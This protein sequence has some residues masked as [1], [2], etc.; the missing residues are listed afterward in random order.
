[1]F[2]NLSTAR[3]ISS[4][5]R[6]WSLRYNRHSDRSGHPLGFAALLCKEPY[7]HVLELQLTSSF[8][9]FLFAKVL[10]IPHFF[11]SLQP[12]LTK[13]DSRHDSTNHA[14]MLVLAAPRI[15]IVYDERQNYI[16]IVEHIHDALVKYIAS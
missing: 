12:Y 4:P 6:L 1:M 16:G 8:Y 3:V 7:L 14:S 9:C 11:V 5:N 2:S 15:R 10:I 13:V